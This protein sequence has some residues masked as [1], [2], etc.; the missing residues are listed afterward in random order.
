MLPT[1]LPTAPRV[2]FA[3]DLAAHGDRVALVSTDEQL[4]YLE[5]A[6]RVARTAQAWGDQRRLVMLHAR[7][8]VDSVVTYL[9]ALAAGHPLLLVGGDQGTSSLVATYQPDLVVGATPTA[10]P[11]SAQSPVG[12][13][14]DTR[15]HPSIVARD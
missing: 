14:R 2:A 6:G 3:A 4:T 12:G 10:L 11:P 13:R 8:D 9:A 7:N 5:L 15:T 1:V